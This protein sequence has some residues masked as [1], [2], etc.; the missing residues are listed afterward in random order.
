MLILHHIVH[1]AFFLHKKS[2][3]MMSIETKI[4]CHLYIIANLCI[5]SFN[6]LYIFVQFF[7]KWTILY[8]TVQN[9]NL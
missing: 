3:I 1:L 4:L 8:Q 9:F 5:Q 7:L 6:I 2:I